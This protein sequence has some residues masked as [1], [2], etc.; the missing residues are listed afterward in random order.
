MPAAGRAS[1]QL[2]GQEFWKES[3]SKKEG[4]ELTVSPN[5]KRG[6]LYKKK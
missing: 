2:S 5:Y 1:G 6:L 4:M 3:G